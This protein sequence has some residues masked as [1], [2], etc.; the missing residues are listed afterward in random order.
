MDAVNYV[1]NRYP[2]DHILIVGDMD[3]PRFDWKQGIVQLNIQNKSLNERFGVI[4]CENN[5]SQMITE[6]AHIMESNLDLMCSTNL[7]EL[8][9]DV[10]TLGSSDHSIL[11]VD[12]QLSRSVRPTCE[13]YRKLNG[14]ELT[15][16]VFQIH[17][18]GCRNCYAA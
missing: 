16:M 13:Q 4:L 9:A 12:I 18:M 8:N 14:N 15:R 6:S 10:I 2:Q 11:T 5:L 3:F 1:F 17:M 7:S